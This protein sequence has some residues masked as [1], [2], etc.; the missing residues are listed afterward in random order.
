MNMTRS[1]MICSY[2]PRAHANE[3][4]NW[5]GGVESLREKI[6][7]V[8]STNPERGISHEKYGLSY[9]ILLSIGL[10]SRNTFISNQTEIVFHGV[11]VYFLLLNSEASCR[12]HSRN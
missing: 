2:E 6:F 5:D 3:F 10:L 8:N 1:M 12:C 4:K 7:G 9:H 11:Y